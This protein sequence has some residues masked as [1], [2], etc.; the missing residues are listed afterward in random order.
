VISSRYT[1]LPDALPQRV[2]ALAQDVAGG[3]DNPYDQARALESFLRQYPYSLE[4]SGPPSGRD[5][6]DYFLFDLQAGYCDYYATAMAVMARALGLPARVAT[7]YLAQPPGETGVQTIYQI[8]AHAWPE[9]YFGGYGWVEF[10][11]TAAFPTRAEI[12]VEEGSPGMVAPSPEPPLATPPIPEQLP[13]RLSP[14]L[15]ALLMFLLAA[16]WLSWRRRR[17]VA[18]PAIPWAYDRLL[19][20]ARGLGVA[21]PASQTPAEMAGALQ[22]QLAPW[23][24]KRRLGGLLRGVRAAADRLTTL[25]ITHQYGRPVTGIV[26]NRP[27]VEAHT[28]WRRLRRPLWLL[29]WLRY[30]T[31]EK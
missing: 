4:V 24:A 27:A 13:D 25:F 26:T 31:G 2:R 12:G 23:E 28:L 22:G 11:P 18:Q 19:R 30:L 16:G 3:Y 5:P 29:R 6:V 17:P 7:G 20:A 1:N 10:E 15:A 8:N 14:W 21:T 9:I